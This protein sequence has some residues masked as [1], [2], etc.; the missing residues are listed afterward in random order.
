MT[1]LSEQT[2][3]IV[4]RLFP[5]ELQAQACDI[6]LKECGNNLP[7]SE[8]ED[9]RGLERVRFAALKLSEGDLSQLRS[10]VEH[11]KVDARDVLMW[12]GFGHSLTAHKE[13][14]QRLVKDMS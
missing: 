10:T 4:R 14:A 6:L 8:A 3:E 1:G 5:P 9:E 11:A 7:F 13:W 2:R 12:A